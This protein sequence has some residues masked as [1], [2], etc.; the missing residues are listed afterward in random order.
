MKIIIAT[1]EFSN[2]EW[3][4]R[5]IRTASDSSL[6]RTGDPL[7]I[8][9]H[10]GKWTG[11][12]MQGVRISRLGTNIP[13]K[14]AGRYFDAVTLALVLAPA[15][16]DSLT[17]GALGIVDRSIAPGEWI[18][19]DTLTDEASDFTTI[20]SENRSTTPTRQQRSAFETCIHELS[21]YCTFKTGDIVLLDELPADYFPLEPDT[22]VKGLIG[23]REV[24]NIKLK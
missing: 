20:Y 22:R 1:P 4:I 8:P 23:E 21:H 24:L 3:S 12:V 13:L 14:F 2:G 6:L 11:K 7:F 19:A 18:S 9:D 15:E 5:E 17:A 10:L 16:Q